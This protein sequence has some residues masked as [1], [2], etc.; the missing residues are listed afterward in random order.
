MPSTTPAKIPAPGRT[1]GL[2]RREALR[3]AAALGDGYY[4][5][6]SRDGWAVLSVPPRDDEPAPAKA[7]ALSHAESAEGAAGLAAK[8][9]SGMP[10]PGKAAVVLDEARTYLTQARD[11]AIQGLKALSQAERDVEA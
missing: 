8:V 6:P 10:L 2:E 7:Q 9:L 3:Q 1:T 5:A 4:A 11:A